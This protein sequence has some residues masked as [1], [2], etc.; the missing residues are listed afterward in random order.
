[1]SHLD[2][3][4]SST[5]SAG[6]V[7]P[8][9]RKSKPGVAPYLRG[10]IPWA[11]IH[12]AMAAGSA[13]LPVTLALWHLRAMKGSTVFTASLRSLCR[14]SGQSAHT[15]RRGLQALEAAGLIARTHIA[16]SNTRITLRAGEIV[17]PATSDRTE[18]DTGQGERA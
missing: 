3:D 14:W 11:W 13:A 4:G 15:A 7:R 16:G 12:Q 17:P 5:S 8:I 9:A 10:P 18:E 1:M 2:T 6:P